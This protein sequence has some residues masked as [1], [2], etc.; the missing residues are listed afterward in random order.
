MAVQR[1]RF[2]RPLRWSVGILAGIVLVAA[3]A[4]VI[5]QVA[6]QRP[7]TLP[8]P[9]GSY[10]VGRSTRQWTDPGRL[11]PLA[12][13]PGQHR[14]LSVWLWYP[15]GPVSGPTAAYAP[16]AWSNLQQQGFLGGPLDAIS[17]SEYDDPPAAD[18]RFPLV[19]LEP[20]L[21]LSAPQFTT[22]AQDLASHGFV[23]AGVTPT[24]SANVTVLDGR[25]VGRTAKGNPDSESADVLGPLV[26]IWAADARFAAARV[27]ALPG[28]DRLAGH[29]DTSRVAYIGHSLGGASSLQACHDD[30][31]CAGAVDLDGTP[32]GPVGSAGLD[33]P[34][35][36]LSSQDGCVAGTCAAGTGTDHEPIESAARSLLA[37]SSGPNW[38]YALAGAQHFNF[39]DYSVYFFLPPLQHL[40]GQLGTI[41]GRRALEITDAVVLAFLDH[42]VRS[43]PAPD[44]LEARY[45]ELRSFP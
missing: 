25:V 8:T 3:G 34:F 12:P 17:T 39:T 40:L 33:K 2:S 32:Y 35:L 29:V 43:G 18:G 44:T 26:Q 11:D 24:F 21:G 22:V 30:P 38:R 37:A 6:R 28:D 1:R 5:A 14:V 45:S 16:G 42:V 10:P 31:D 23:V 27:A 20:G 13:Q 19:V 4:A 41:N 15:A 9:T 36:L 7:R